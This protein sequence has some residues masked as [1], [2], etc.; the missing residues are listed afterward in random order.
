MISAGVSMGLESVPGAGRPSH[1]PVT[2]AVLSFNLLGDAWR[3]WLDPRTRAQLEF[4]N[5]SR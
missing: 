1:P 4:A 2:I 3:D 5:L